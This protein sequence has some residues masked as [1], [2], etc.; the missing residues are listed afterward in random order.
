[1]CNQVKITVYVALK[2]SGYFDNRLCAEVLSLLSSCKGGARV[3]EHSFL[4]K[5]YVPMYNMYY[6]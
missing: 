6:G 1:M 4:L 3:Q 2:N 5:K